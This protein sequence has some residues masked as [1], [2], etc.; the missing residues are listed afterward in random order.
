MIV[1]FRQLDLD[2][3]G[4]LKVHSVRIY[5]TA[6][7]G[8]IFELKNCTILRL[9]I[10]LAITWRAAMCASEV[11]M[12]HGMS[13]CHSS[14]RFAE[15]KS[16]DKLMIFILF[17]VDTAS[18]HSRRKFTAHMQLT[19]PIE[20]RFNVCFN[21]QACLGRWTFW[22]AEMLFPAR[23]RPRHTERLNFVDLPRRH[24]IRRNSMF[25][26]VINHESPKYQS[27]WT[28]WSFRTERGDIPINGYR[29]QSLERWQ[30]SN[31]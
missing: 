12:D 17:L 28:C 10:R 14:V 13:L 31:D 9:P 27:N 21:I 1:G 6:E 7:S 5:E 29:E 30:F 26:H 20:K 3:A 24:Q 18:A 15:T 19:F 25:D 22:H 4:S 23:I 11:W 8:F 16:N 2:S